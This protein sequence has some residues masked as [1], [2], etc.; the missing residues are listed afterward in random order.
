LDMEAQ[1]LQKES[2]SDRDAG[3]ES[4]DEERTNSG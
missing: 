3:V 1:M 2:T 4:T